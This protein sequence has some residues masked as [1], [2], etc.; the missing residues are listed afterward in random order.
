M[1]GS[2][3]LV[4]IGGNSCPEGRGFESQQHIF[5]VKMVMFV[6]KEEKKCKEA[7]DG[8]F[9]KNHAQDVISGQ[10]LI[11]FDVVMCLFRNN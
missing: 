9:K 10:R 5:V 11:I 1:G 7:R 2:P 4:V 6:S 8:P 3:C